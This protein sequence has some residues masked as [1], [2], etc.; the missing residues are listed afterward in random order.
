[1]TILGKSHKTTKKKLSH[2]EKIPKKPLEQPNALD[3]VH[4]GAKRFHLEP[5]NF[6]C[7][8]EEV[9][10]VI[11]PM[12]YD[13]MRLYCGLVEDSTEFR[14]NIHTYNNSFAFTSLDAKYDHKLTKNMKRVYTFRVQG[15]VYYFLNSLKP[16][17][18][19]LFGIQLYFYDTEEEF[20]RR[21]DVSP[22]LH[23][24]TVKL[25]MNVL[26]QNPYAKFFKGLRDIPNL[27]N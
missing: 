16:S 11:P 22:R 15:Q 6:C 9:S 20:S 27:E 23:E 26:G 24:S 19:P 5:P 10:F 14:K 8:G 1:M 25:L 3:C 17:A 13:I 18:D 12:L 4:C 2:L 7:A 21:F